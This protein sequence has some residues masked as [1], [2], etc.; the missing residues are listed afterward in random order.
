MNIVQGD[1][2]SMFIG[3]PYESRESAS[4]IKNKII[5]IV[6]IHIRC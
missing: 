5:A 4:T 2:P 1:N 6:L 3:V